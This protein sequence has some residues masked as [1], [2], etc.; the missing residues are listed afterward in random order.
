MGTAAA[1]LREKLSVL[2]GIYIFIFDTRS[3]RMSSS[4]SESSVWALGSLQ[5][6]TSYAPCQAVDLCVLCYPRKPPTMELYVSSQSCCC[7]GIWPK[8]TSVTPP[9]P[10]PCPIS[11]WHGP[12]WRIT[13]GCMVSRV[14][15]AASH[16]YI[17]LDEDDWF[18]RVPPSLNKWPEDGVHAHS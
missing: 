2:P 6:C 15:T 7:T 16:V 4:L 17:Q 1:V 14:R 11:F 5:H 9:L 18:I 12:S 10:T 8:T 13:T 3:F